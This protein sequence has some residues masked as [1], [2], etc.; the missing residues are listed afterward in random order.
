MQSI[1]PNDE[2]EEHTVSFIPRPPNQPS[3]ICNMFHNTVSNSKL[4]RKLGGGKG[5][6]ERR[7]AHLNRTDRSA[8]QR[9]YHSPLHQSLS[10][11]T[12]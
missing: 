9:V 1:Q 5:V 12:D 8:Q 11:A 2:Q 7:L 10:M 4:Y 6:L 3:T